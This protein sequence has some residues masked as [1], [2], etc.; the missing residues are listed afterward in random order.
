M[1]VHPPGTGR[2]RRAVGRV[3][4]GLLA[5]ASAAVAYAVLVVLGH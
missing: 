3:A 1:T 5:A 2:A 4:L